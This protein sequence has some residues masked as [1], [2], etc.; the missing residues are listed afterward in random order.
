MTE[1]FTYT[2]AKEDNLTRHI[3]ANIRAIQVIYGLSPEELG[4]IMGNVGRTLQETS[5]QLEALDI[6]QR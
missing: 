3:Y 6:T 2:G 5:G 1:Q 4:R